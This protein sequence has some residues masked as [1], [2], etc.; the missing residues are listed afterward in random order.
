M[1]LNPLNALSRFGKRISPSLSGLISQ[2]LKP[3]FFEKAP[4]APAVPKATDHGPLFSD[5]VAAWK[6]DRFPVLAHTTRSRYQRTLRD[7]LQCFFEIPIR[8]I[9]PKRIDEWLQDRKEKARGLKRTLRQKFDLELGVLAAIFSFYQNYFDDTS[10]QYPIKKRHRQSASLNGQSY[11]RPPKDL[12][13]ADFHKFLQALQV[14]KYGELLKN[15]ALVQWGA[16]LRISE[17]AALYWEDVHFDQENPSRSRIRIVR[18]VCYV[19]DS[20]VEP[21][22]KMGF[23]NARTNKGEKNLPLFPEAYNALMSIRKEGQTGLIFSIDGKPIKYSI[24]QSQYNRAFRAASLPFRSTHVMRHGRCRH[25]FNRHP[26][27]AIAQALLGNDLK[28]TMIYAVRDVTALTQ[29][30]VQEWNE[31][32]TASP[33][34]PS[35]F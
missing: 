19:H 8:D 35:L 31:S 21:Y 28:S 1:L 10:F 30:A 34:S 22:V 4:T 26:D 27:P 18:S 13:E 3:V 24:I 15:L 33:K 17:A 16:A 14:G 23:K 2:R 9:T 7:H 5:V 12:K 20:R 25:V 11:S 6:R 29:V 32:A